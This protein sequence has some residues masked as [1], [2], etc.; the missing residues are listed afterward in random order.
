MCAGKEYGFA[1]LSL[2]ANVKAGWCD[3]FPI[4]PVVVRNVDAGGP[5]GQNHLTA[6]KFDAAA[7]SMGWR[8][9]GDPGLTAVVGQKTI[10]FAERVV[11]K[12]AADNDQMW[13]P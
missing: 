10:L 4:H 8:G 9:G 5:A 13:P 7:I 6:D 1:I 11:G 3:Q 12:I 2:A